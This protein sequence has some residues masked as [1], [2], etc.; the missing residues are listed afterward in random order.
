MN[1]TTWDKKALLRQFFPLLIV[2]S[3]QQLIS[4]SVN[5]V[6][7]MM[8]GTYDE[9]ALSG[10]ALVNQL[11]FMLSQVA[12]GVG[13]GVTVLG[14]QYWGKMRTEPIKKL[15]AI[16]LKFSF[17]AGIIFFAAT[18]LFPR[19]A[20]MLFSRDE[21]VIAQGL[22]YLDV[23]RWSYIIFSIS[24]VLM[25][26]LQSVQTA[27]IGTIMSGC[28]I[29][30]NASLNYLLIFGNLGAPE[31]GITGAAIATLIS[32]CVELV[33]IL[34]YILVF[35]KKLKMKFSDLLG[36]DR[37]YLRDYIK[38]ASPII[39]TGSLWGVAQATQTAI[40]GHIS[41]TAIA[42]NSIASIVFQL[43]AVFGMCCASASAVTMGKTI[44][45]GKM[46]LVRPYARAFQLIFIIIGVLSGL[47]LFL[48]KEI[49]VDFYA[50]TPETRELTISFIT[51]L[52]ITTAFSCY[53]Y[54]TMS[55]IIAGGGET[56]YAA[57]VDNG[58]MWLFTIPLSV[59]SAFVFS[60]PPEITFI[61]LKADQILK[62][63]P[64][65]IVCNRFRW[66]KTLTRDE[67]EAKIEA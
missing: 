5:L 27:F 11:Q 16:G 59:L 23:M 41:A 43:F 35:D 26:S 51:I 2:I 54:P 45:E 22:L 36:F 62:C 24:A 55:G 67:G 63:I 9:A 60:W 46:H 38:I 58:F 20:L 7:N 28:T 66:I 52:S 29:I 61:C 32:R 31:L 49:I 33:V 48:F 8:L 13:A 56:R 25:Y 65:A 39:I 34:V 53:E 12:V 42:A 30:I 50:V 64:N 10:A 57:F 40:L 18:S 4:L 17:A 1:K 6:D 15:I 14:A 19:G 21:A 3:L 44:G 47:L 37:T